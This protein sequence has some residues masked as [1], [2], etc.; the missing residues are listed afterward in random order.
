MTEKERIECFI[1][2]LNWDSSH[3]L[4]I[5]FFLPCENFKIK[6]VGMCFGSDYAR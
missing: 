2:E 3:Y 1:Q 5:F 4:E 6:L